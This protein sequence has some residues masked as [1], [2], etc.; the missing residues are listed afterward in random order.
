MIIGLLK[1]I[2]NSIVKIR[3]VFY[4]N[5]RREYF[6]LINSLFGQSPSLLISDWSLLSAGLYRVYNYLSVSSYSSM[7]G[8]KRY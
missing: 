7:P 2:V 3:I 1:R 8:Y 6:Q 5:F 4:I